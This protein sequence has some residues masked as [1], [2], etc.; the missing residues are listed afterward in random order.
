MPKFV[1]VLV[2]LFGLIGSG[3]IPSNQ[4]RI[5]TDLRYPQNETAPANPIIPGV[6]SPKANRAT[7]GIE[8]G[9][10]IPSR[11]LKGSPLPTTGAN[12][13]AYPHWADRHGLGRPLVKGIAPSLILEQKSN[14][15]VLGLSVGNP[16][17]RWNGIAIGLGFAPIWL[18]GSIHIHSVDIEKT[19]DPLINPTT[20]MVK[21]A[22]ILVIDPGH[23][24]ANFGT[25]SFD[26]KLVEKDLTLD[27]AKRIQRTLSAHPSSWTVLLTRTND[28]ELSGLQRVS[29]AD[30]A[31]ADLFIS[32][33]FNSVPNNQV[34][35]G[36]ETYCTTPQGLPSNLTREFEDVTT[37]LFPNNHFDGDNF[38]YA[39][40]LHQTLLQLTGRKDRGLRRARFMTVLR[41]QN[42]PAVL[43]EGG[44]VSSP[45]EAR[46]IATPEYRQRLAEA[47]V[48][49]LLDQERTVPQITP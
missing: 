25:R 41:E 47:I 29:I 13:V 31:N 45:M 38:Y 5:V 21:G 46:L 30:A 16:Y 32:L 39:L 1:Q 48:I 2:L 17:I 18:E 15:G 3:C 22:K 42:R 44:Y 23:G 8:S 36:L 4:T 34:E 49:A 6:D 24:G 43:I 28:V 7:L 19:L 20:L 12:W 9:G 26:G 27:W 10:T 11:N 40:E 37:H 14:H 33:H 35:M